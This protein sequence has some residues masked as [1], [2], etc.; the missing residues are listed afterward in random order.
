MSRPLGCYGTR[1]SSVKGSTGRT[2]VIR[3]Q[4]YELVSLVPFWKV[5]PCY[6]R[7][8][9]LS[10]TVKKGP[11][12]SGYRW[13]KGLRG[14]PSRGSEVLPVA[15]HTLFSLARAVPRPCEKGSYVVR[16]LIAWLRVS[17]SS[18]SR[19]KRVLRG[20]AVFAHPPLFLR[21]P[22]GAGVWRPRGHC[23]Q[24]RG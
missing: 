13:W 23:P 16:M 15:V 17:R 21:E 19:A 3:G 8:R 22:S 12:E 9:V 7:S 14:T 18:A 4:G 10:N 2:C 24:Q 20:P 6:C 5:M 11:T 1:I